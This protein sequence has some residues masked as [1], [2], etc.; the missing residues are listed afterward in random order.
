MPAKQ[1]GWARKRKNGWQACW[2]EGDRQRVGPQLFRSKTE[3]EDWLEDKLREGRALRGFDVTFSAHVERYLRVHSAVV[4]PATIRTLRERLGASEEEPATAKAAQRRKRPY[5]TAIETFGE[6]T[7]AEL[8]T[9][10]ADIAEWQ[11]TLPTGYRH[12]I[13]RALRQV[14]NAAVRWKLIRVNPANEVGPN[15]Q[16]PRQEVEF[17]QSLADVDKLA[18]E[19]GQSDPERHR[20][21]AA[22]GPV[23]VFGVETGLRP[24][25]W[26]ALER[27]DIDRVAKI[28]RVRR[29]F[30][31][32]RTKEYGKTA[33]SRRNVPL[34]ARALQALDQLPARIDTPLLFPARA[35]GHI[36][37]D[38]W[39]RRE[40]VPAVEAA[41]LSG[42]LSPY[43]M[44][45]TYASYA[46][47]AGVS[48][49]ELA[50]LM[51]TSVKVIDSTYG[52][53]V[54]DSFDRVRT[55]LEQRARREATK[56][57]DATGR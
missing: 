46:L 30:V 20:T 53:L 18:I 11:S 29:S 27:R 25:E 39:R 5:K 22:F 8:E 56:T 36:D 44:R 1:R 23:A 41:G 3:A 47:D 19:L 31:D 50:R 49:F 4:D 16:P 55:A 2:R 40:W 43:S 48:I 28:V 24:S 9:M 38:N 45:H 14:L 33:R 42:D 12:A 52:H 34:T 57:K 21:S 35:G 15:P 54:R 32:G 51:G 26:I 17:F 6:L 13:V 37:L 7:L 10:S